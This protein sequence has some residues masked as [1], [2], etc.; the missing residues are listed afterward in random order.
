MST[1]AACVHFLEPD[2]SRP[3]PKEAPMTP[4]T[5]LLVAAAA[6]LAAR[7]AAQSFTSDATITMTMSWREATSTGGTIPNPDGILEP[8]EHA[9]ILIDS[10]SFTNQG[11]T[12]NF[13]PPIGTFTSG[14]I[15][16]FGAG[17]LDINGSGG[18]VGAFNY[19]VPL[20][21]PTGTSGFGVRGSYRAGGPFLNPASDGIINLQFGQF[22]ANPSFATSENPITNMFRFLWT[23]NSFTARTIRFDTAGA[24]VAGGN[25]AAVYLDFDHAN[26]GSIYVTPANLT[27]GSVSIP[28]AP[29]P[30]TLILAAA[31]LW[32]GRRRRAGA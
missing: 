13:S 9:L 16:G 15:L 26:G 28:I 8:G 14:T 11:G 20:A 2:R 25:V 6:G 24:S 12:A 21:N 30:P 3:P 27:L 18:T 22:P 1:I 23:P 5:P 19:S 32:A 10:V 17:L 31:G 4:R 29:A 7:A